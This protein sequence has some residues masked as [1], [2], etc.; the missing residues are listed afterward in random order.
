M[1]IGAAGIFNLIGVG[2]RKVSYLVLRLKYVVI[3][4]GAPGVKTL[5][6]EARGCLC[7]LIN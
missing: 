4:L 1:T 6:G 3:K 2:E 5:P 7:L